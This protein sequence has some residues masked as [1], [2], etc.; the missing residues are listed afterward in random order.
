MPGPAS[1]ESLVFIKNA[2]KVIV[3][4]TGE[5]KRYR[6]MLEEVEAIVRD[7]GQNK[8]DLD[9]VT[10]KVQRGF[11]IIKAMKARLEETRTQIEKLRPG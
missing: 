5:S 8:Q 7:L 9:E 6:E 3:T 2:E 11:E 10:G 1:H 4:Q